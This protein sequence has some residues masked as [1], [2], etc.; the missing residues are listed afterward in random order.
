MTER[1]QSHRYELLMPL[2]VLVGMSSHVSQEQSAHLR[3][4]STHGIYFVSEESVSP[5]T[6]VN[7]TF[8]LP[9]DRG[10]PGAVFVRGS[11]RAL[12][13]DLVPGG[14]S[15]LFGVAASIG[16]FDFGHPDQCAA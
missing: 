4:I 1:R 10:R 13:V 16:R 2:Q 15:S 9:P 11:G 12:R 3:D 7:V 5:G 6:L 8:T 14:N